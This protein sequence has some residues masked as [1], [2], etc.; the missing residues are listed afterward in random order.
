MANEERSYLIVGLGN[1]EPEY[2]KTRHNFGANLLKYIG[3]QWNIPKWRKRFDGKYSFTEFEGLRVHLLFPLTYMNLSG[4]SVAKARKKFS[5][6]KENIIVL[7]DDVDIGFGVVK[8]KVG[9]G[10]G[11][12]NGLK[13]IFSSFGSR[14]FIRVRLGVGRPPYDMVRYVLGRFSKDERELLSD[15]YEKSSISVETILSK[16]V[17]YAMNATNGK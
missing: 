3:N 13:S 10:A 16:G 5:I 1:P 9:G 11:G 12:H 4:Q 7:H 2:E 6:P 8:V 15:I 14:D 17:T